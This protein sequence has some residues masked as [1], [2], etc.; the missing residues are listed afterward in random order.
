MTDPTS[1]PDAG[2]L[3]SVLG[4]YALDALE[5]DELAAV[6]AEALGLPLP[7]LKRAIQVRWSS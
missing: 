7:G 5:P 6:E 4:A 3:D 1:V 2:E